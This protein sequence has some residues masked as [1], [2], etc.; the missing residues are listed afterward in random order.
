VTGRAQ[1]Q[2][3]TVTGNPVAARPWLILALTCGAQ[4]MGVLDVTIVNVALPSMQQD[5][6]LSAAE[7]QWVVNSYTLTFAG[8]L[9]LGGRAADV[10]GLK[11]VF[12]VGLAVFTVASL[13]GGLAQEGWQLVAARA[14]QGLGGAIFTPAT[15]TMVT[16][17]FSKPRAQAK[18]LGI[19]SAVAGAGGAL[20]GVI[21]GLLTGILSWRWVLIVNVPL[22]IVLFVAAVWL[23]P[24]DRLP[25]TRP[26]LDHPGAAAVT[27]G[28]GCLIGGIIGLEQWGWSA[29]ATLGLFGAAL[30]LLA[31]FLVVERRVAQPLVPLSIFQV[32][33]VAV[34]NLLSLANSGVIPAVFFFLSLY[35]QLVLGMDP[36]A[37]GLA[38]MPAALGIAAGSVLASRLVVGLGS[39]I[40]VFAGSALSAAAL[41][42]LS[43]IT[44]DGNYWVQ[45]PA[46]L[47]LSMV[48]LGVTGL[49]LTM[50]ATSGVRRDQQGLTAGL[51]NTARQIGGAIGMAAFVALAAAVTRT[52]TES[53]AAS[54]AALVGGFRAAWLVGAGVLLATGLAAIALPKPVHTHRERVIKEL[55][56][57]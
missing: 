33:S 34:A 40:V 17:T 57:G 51:L 27:L 45:V 11:R 18:A 13:A 3:R 52:L 1:S 29:P 19:W 14:L 16:T 7:L 2:E 48:G 28:A 56:R 36:L 9:L 44:P 39:R 8:F 42:W 47:F 32:R 55:H 38:M 4:F 24:A 53:G 46:P 35:L 37:A 5:L 41:A 6:G 50:A 23:M 20:G 43:F 31:V 26:K 22:G 49:P 25:E 30:M 54:S 12:L 15:L 21:G 10:F